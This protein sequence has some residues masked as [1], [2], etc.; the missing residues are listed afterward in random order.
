MGEGV[1]RQFLLVFTSEGWKWPWLR[2]QETLF[3]GSS[4]FSLVPRPFIQCVRISLLVLKAISTGVGWVWDRDYKYALFC[5]NRIILW[6]V[7]CS[8]WRC[9]SCLVCTGLLMRG[10]W[11]WRY[12]S[13]IG[14]RY[15]HSNTTSIY[16]A[17]AGGSVWIQRKGTQ[18]CLQ[19]SH[20][21]L[22]QYSTSSTMQL[23]TCTC[24]YAGF[25]PFPTLVIRMTVWGIYCWAAPSQ[26]CEHYTRHVL[27]LQALWHSLQ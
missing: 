18:I 5:V 26:M 17:W 22:W 3:V 9:P 2:T 24:T 1:Q 13:D 15:V 25:H 6:T 8:P 12:S 7:F 16:V 20:R 21:F 11:N 19:C 10:L 23:R 27:K 14:Q 4:L